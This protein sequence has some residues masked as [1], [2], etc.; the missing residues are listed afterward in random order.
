MLSCNKSCNDLGQIICVGSGPVPL[1]RNLWLKVF[2]LCLVLTSMDRVGCC[3]VFDQQTLQLMVKFLW[4]MKPVFHWSCK[5]YK[6]FSI[7]YLWTIIS[8]LVHLWSFYLP[9]LSCIWPSVLILPLSCMRKREGERV[10][11]CVCVSEVI[12][13]MLCEE[14]G[15]K[16]R[17]LSLE[18]Y[19]IK[20]LQPSFF[21]MQH[22]M[23]L[24]RHLNKVLTLY[25]LLSTMFY[26]I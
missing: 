9:L 25:T 1:P 26:L 21:V 12:R 22:S 4:D 2:S 10:C 6:M 8:A 15:L 16:K 11:V 3:G 17:A 23:V 14:C 20:H 13:W 5:A 18:V 7:I 19:Q 24:N